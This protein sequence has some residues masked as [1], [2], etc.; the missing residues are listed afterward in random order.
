MNSLGL[1][2]MLTVQG[3]VSLITIL[4]IRKVMKSDKSKK[5]GK[6]SQMNK[7]KSN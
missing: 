3:L 5:I 4:L 6:Q 2:W 7:K 1:I